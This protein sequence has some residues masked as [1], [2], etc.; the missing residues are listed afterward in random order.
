MS[1]SKSM[2]I[3]GLVKKSYCIAD[4]K[5]WHSLPATIPERLC[6]IHSEVSEA[7]EDYRS[8][9]EPSAIYYE[10]TYGA[11]KPCGI[12]IELADIVIRVADFCG[13]YGIDLQEA[14]RIKEAYNETRP[15]LHGGKKL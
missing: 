4:S 12:P 10:D 3:N 14:I 1:A 15:H 11:K 5:G 9:R 13:I 7:L 6:L 2:T 8:G